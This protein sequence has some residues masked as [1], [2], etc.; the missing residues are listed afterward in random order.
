VRALKMR[1]E[2]SENVKFS[3]IESLESKEFEMAHN[4]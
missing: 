4:I 2:S 1:R 3:N